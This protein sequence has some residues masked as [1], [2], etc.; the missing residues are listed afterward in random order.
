[1]SR[2]P[3][4]MPPVDTG[5][6]R[7]SISNTARYASGLSLGADGSIYAGGEF[8]GITGERKARWNGESWQSFDADDTS[9]LC[10]QCGGEITA[11]H[12]RCP[13]C[14][15]ATVHST[16]CRWCG[17]GN[18]KAAK[19]CGERGGRWLAQMGC[20]AEDWGPSWWYDKEKF[21]ITIAADDNKFRES[22]GVMEKAAQN[23]QYQMGEAFLP[24]LE[25]MTEALVPA[26]TGAL[27][28]AGLAKLR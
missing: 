28:G 18:L 17:C 14:G 7:A 20:G 25:R 10:L 13:G 1:M 6:L 11:S 5:A 26:I 2:K 27:I 22:M 21:S 23:L 4:R 12:I 9:A 3:K 16:A 15:V 8:V 19:R 24:A